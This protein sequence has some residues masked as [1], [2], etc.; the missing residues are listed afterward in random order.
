MISKLSETGCIFRRL[1]WAKSIHPHAV[2]V[3]QD[4]CT[5]DVDPGVCCYQMELEH[6]WDILRKTIAFVERDSK[7]KYQSK[8]GSPYRAHLISSFE[9]SPQDFESSSDQYFMPKSIEQVLHAKD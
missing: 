5:R 6:E 9:K 2:L 7:V 8:C 3:V 1:S 4:G